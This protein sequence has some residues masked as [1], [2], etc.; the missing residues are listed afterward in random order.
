MRGSWSVEQ[1]KLDR[2]APQSIAFAAWVTHDAAQAA[3]GRAGLNLDSLT[4]AAARREFRPVA[5]GI[6]VAV[7]ITSALRHVRSEN[8]VAKIPGGDRALARQAVLFTAHWDH[9][10]IGPVANGDSIYNGAEDN[11]SGVAAML[12][13][14]E[15]LAQVQPR[16]RRTLLF[17][18]TTAEES[19][20]LGSEAYT[21]DP[22]VPL[23]QT[24]AVINLDVANVRGTTRDI[25][26]LGIERSTLG[27][28]FSAAASAESLA[29][30]HEPD[31]RGSFYRSDHFPFSKA[32]VPALSIEPGRDF[33]GRPVGWG[34]QEAAR[35][36]R[37]RYHQPG[38]EY[39]ATFSYAGMAQEVRV[40]MRVALA[41]ANASA[42]PRWLPNSEFQR[43]AARSLP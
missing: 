24:A 20:L 2:P 17:V 18:A 38:D 3:L 11:A 16:P 4:R 5:T 36:N 10:G 43:P 37:E 27:A 41:V 34:A 28:V 35:Y 6:N 15:A 12:G 1:F 32:G 31:V 40:A 39:R 9:K 22:L 33:V 8:V 13:A 21:R 14:A 7:D 26:A 23:E 25:D 29:V 30:V 42:M 19:G